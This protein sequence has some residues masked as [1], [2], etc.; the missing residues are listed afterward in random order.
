MSEAIP[1]ALQRLGAD[2]RRIA[3]GGV[4]MG[5]FGAYDLARLNPHRFCAVGGHSAALWRNGGETAPGAFDER[6]RLRAQQR[7]RRGQPVLRPVSGARLWLDVG[8][9]DPFRSADS[10]LAHE[11]QAK[12]SKLQF[13][14]WE[15]GHEGAYW[16]SHWAAYLHF[17]ASALAHCA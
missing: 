11:L 1:Q 8:T 3:I 16:R 4:S 15:G 7:D 5:G 9:R 12:G 17:Y 10:E 14:V 13:H 6:R 2:P